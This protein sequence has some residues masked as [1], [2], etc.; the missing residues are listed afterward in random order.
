M[1]DNG[2]DWLII[3]GASARAAAQSSIRAGFKPWCV[4]LFADRDLQAIAPVTPCRDDQYPGAIVQH[5]RAAGLPAESPILITGAMENHSDVL[6][7]LAAQ[8]PLLGCSPSSIRKVRDPAAIGLLAKI[9]GI[10]FCDVRFEPPTA[11]H[12]YLVKPRR[13]AG[14][15]G[16]GRWSPGQPVTCGQYLQQHVPGLAISAVYA[17]HGDRGAIVGVTEQIIGCRAF[18]T[19]GFRYCGSLGPA[20]L[21]ERQHTALD[22]LG[23]MLIDRFDL[24]GVFGVDAVIDPFGDVWPVEVN[25]RYT[26]SVELIERATD[27]AVLN[28]AG[29]TTL[30]TPSRTCGKAI[31]FA[32]RDVTT[33]DLYQLFPAPNLA[34]VPVPGQRIRKGR[35]ICT[36]FAEGDDRDACMQRLRQMAQ[37]VY[38]HVHP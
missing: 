36:V 35:P 21:T 7:A 37:V 30:N 17:E 5:V 3:V 28:L 38:T 27:I 15:H 32:K 20:Q 26:S 14:G 16:I 9:P 34:D 31:V 13:G 10:H 23:R 1:N 24:H 25:P 19:G 8:H 18:G 2:G 22:R 33:E 11:H 12:D 6:D 29:N 4:D